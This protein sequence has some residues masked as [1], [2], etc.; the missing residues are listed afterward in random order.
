M[1]SRYRKVPLKAHTPFVLIN[2][3]STEHQIGT[4]IAMNRKKLFAI[5]GLIIITYLAFHSVVDS[6]G[7][8]FISI[9]DCEVANGEIEEPCRHAMFGVPLF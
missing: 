6:S 4:Q 5:V 2:T 7:R 3:E 9:K 1:D 8:H